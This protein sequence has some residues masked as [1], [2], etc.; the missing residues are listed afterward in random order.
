M[1]RSLVKNHP[2]VDGNKRV[3]M[4]VTVVF[5]A[6]NG[7]ILVASNNEMVRFALEL[8]GRKPDMDWREVAAW[9]KARTVRRAAPEA[10]MRSR[11]RVIVEGKSPSERAALRSTLQRYVEAFDDV[12]QELVERGPSR[13][14]RA[15]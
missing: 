5:L 8:A 3:G 12:A 13:S 6:V 10:E 15:R 14:E 4:T 9:L 1:L 11:L 2:L 7:H